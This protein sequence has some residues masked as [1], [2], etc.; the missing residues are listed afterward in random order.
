MNDDESCMLRPLGFPRGMENQGRKLSDDIKLGF[1]ELRPVF[2]FAK[3]GDGK[4]DFFFFREK[5]LSIYIFNSF[6]GVFWTSSIHNA[7]AAD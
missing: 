7:R 3:K 2:I 4:V 5:V 6:S 1:S